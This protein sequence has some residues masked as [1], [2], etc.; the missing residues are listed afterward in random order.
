MIKKLT[1]LAVTALFSLN[2]SAGYIQW[3]V[4]S[5]GLSGYVVQNEQDLSIAYFELN[6][7]RPYEIMYT[8]APSMGYSDIAWVK[9]QRNNKG[10]SNFEIAN[11]DT[12]GLSSHLR[13]NFSGTG[14]PDIYRFRSFYKFEQV[15]SPFP[16]GEY[17]LP[18][19]THRAQGKVTR[20]EVSTELASQLDYYL[21]LTDGERY[22]DLLHHVVPKLNV[23]PEPTS[24]ALFALG[25]A[26]L[27]GFRRRKSA[28]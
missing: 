15:W 1:A 12:E 9:A 25:A 21:E 22:D 18:T 14:D 4:E 6:G 28:V 20:G 24:I 26:G 13:L 2:A 5:S 17:S 11:E 27:A 7:V 19:V 16:D 3:N 23:I 10:P 8:F